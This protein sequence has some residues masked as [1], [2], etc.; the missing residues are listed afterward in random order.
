MKGD[1]AMLIADP[2]KQIKTPFNAHRP[3]ELKNPE[4]QK[5]SGK[6]I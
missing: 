5:E 1:T 3:S 6:V 4:R 2:P